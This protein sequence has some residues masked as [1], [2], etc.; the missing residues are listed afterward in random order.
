MFWLCLYVVVSTISVSG[1]L[2]LEKIMGC[3]RF[4]KKPMMILNF[5]F[6]SPLKCWYYICHIDIPCPRYPHRYF[7]LYKSSNPGFH[8]WAW[9]ECVSNVL[10]TLIFSQL[11]GFNQFLRVSQRKLIS[12]F[13]AS[14]RDRKPG[15]LYSNILLNVHFSIN[16][17]T[18]G[19]FS[20]I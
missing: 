10:F 14:S 8:A 1:E 15:T 4:A 6:F 5:W 11:Y 19:N 16:L 13:G 7:I 17:K 18:E 12:L 20:I 3:L 2:G 9:S